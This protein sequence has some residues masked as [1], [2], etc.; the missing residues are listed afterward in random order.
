MPS[1]SLA[2]L[3]RFV[4]SFGF[5]PFNS[6]SSLFLNVPSLQWLQ[7]PGEDRKSRYYL[8]AFNLTLRY[9]EL[10]EI[11]NKQIKLT[12]MRPPSAMTERHVQDLLAI[13]PLQQTVA[14]K[15]L[16]FDSLHS[17]SSNKSWG[18]R[19]LSSKLISRRATPSHHSLNLKLCR[20]YQQSAKVQTPVSPWVSLITML[21]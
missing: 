8:Q 13:L 19:I 10:L 7:R 4:H 21:E 18:S 3:H 20:R 5:V 16:T 2:L 14:N 15:A 12:Q 1:L 6:F 17:R 11:R 9:F